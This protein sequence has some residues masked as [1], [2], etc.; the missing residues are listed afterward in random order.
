MEQIFRSYSQ[1][2][3]KSQGGPSNSEK[4]H[5]NVL[6][7]AWLCQAGGT[8]ETWRSTQAYIL[9]ACNSIQNMNL[10]HHNEN[11][12]HMRADDSLKNTSLVTITILL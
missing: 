7:P 10:P 8:T 6:S 9:D 2:N 4:P 1:S 3:W 5:V 11:K 12:Q